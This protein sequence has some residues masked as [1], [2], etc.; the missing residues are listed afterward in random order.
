MDRNQNDIVNTALLGKVQSIVT[1][2]FQLERGTVT[3][4]SSPKEIE[5]W[6]SVQHLNLVLALEQHFG[7]E[8]EPEEMEAIRT[9]GDIV[10]L[11]A[12]KVDG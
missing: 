2:L 1:D 4:T 3:L 12:R 8:F 5:Q 6:D 11:I 10:A 9:V 7:V